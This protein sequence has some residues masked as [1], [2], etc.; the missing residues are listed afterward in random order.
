MLMCAKIMQH[1]VKYTALVSNWPQ[2]FPV[3]NEAKGE[4]YTF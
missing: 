3:G 1:N 4:L 2:K